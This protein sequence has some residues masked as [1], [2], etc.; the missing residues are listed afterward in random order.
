MD[1]SQRS[2]W[3]EK[4]LQRL[5][6]NDTVEGFVGD[7][8]RGLQ[9][10][11]DRRA[12]SIRIIQNVALDYTFGAVAARIGGVAEFEDFA[13]HVT[14]VLRQESLDEVSIHGETTVIAPVPAERRQTPQVP[15]IYAHILDDSDAHAA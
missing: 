13:M 15:K 10:S 11:N 6:Q 8:G 3:L 14:G 4:E 2:A 12:R 5:S 9:I 1:R 7:L